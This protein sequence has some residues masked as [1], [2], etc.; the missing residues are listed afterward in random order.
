M[1][2]YLYQ[3]LVISFG[4]VRIHSTSP[5]TWS[6]VNYPLRPPF[7]CY[8]SIFL[9]SGFSSKYLSANARIVGFSAVSTNIT[10]CLVSRKIMIATLHGA[11][12]IIPFRGL[13]YWLIP[14]K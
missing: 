4:S 1:L 8:P 9:A 13:F 14:T 3:T 5:C 7:A 12:A 6:T 2:T 10:L 11:L